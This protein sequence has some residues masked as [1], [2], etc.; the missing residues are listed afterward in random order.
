[1]SAASRVENGAA[2][3]A[4]AEGAAPS[5]RRAVAVALTVA[6]IVLLD[7]LTKVWAVAALA[8][9]PIS[10]VGETVEFRVTRNPGGAFGNFRGMT[11][12]LA[13]GAAVI[14]VFL[15]RAV[16]RAT[17]PWVVV[18]LTL[19]LGG[20]CGNLVDR[21]VRSPGF[22]RGHV[23]DFVAVGSFPVFNLADSCVTVGAV[24]LVLCSLRP[25]PR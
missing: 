19:L 4:V 7:Q 23:V 1:M 6:L 3:G 24:I 16:R 14:A 12:V 25:E 22:L 13:V 2:D 17:D 8:D 15:F 9:G 10:V 5:A 21:L 18:G 20:A 11:P